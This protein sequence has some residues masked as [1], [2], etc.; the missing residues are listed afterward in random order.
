MPTALAAQVKIAQH[1]PP[2]PLG[3][4][5]PRAA[6]TLWGAS[7]PPAAAYVRQRPAIPARP[8]ASLPC[9]RQRLSRARASCAPTVLMTDDLLP[10]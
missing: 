4:P 7:L 10:S 9:P 1:H 3:R 2:E 8:G 6:R 5:Q